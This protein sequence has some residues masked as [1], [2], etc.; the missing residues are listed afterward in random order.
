MRLKRNTIIADTFSLPEGSEVILN[1]WVNI[2]RNLGGILFLDLRDRSGIIQ[3][4]FD[5]EFLKTLRDEIGHIATEDVI[6]VKG[7]VQTRPLEAINKNMP[8]GHMEILVNDFELLN[9]AKTTPFEITKRE[10]GSEDLRLKYRYLDLRTTEM[11]KNMLLRSK[12]AASVRRFMDS[13]DFMDIETPM[14]MKS[15][16]EGARDYLVPSRVNPGKFYALPQSPQTYKQLLMIAGF[17]KYYQITKCFRDEDLRADRQPEFTQIDIEMSFVDENDVMTLA[18][19]LLASV[20]MD[21]VNKELS[22][23]LKRIPYHEAMEKYGS[24]K[25]DT[26]IETEIINIETIAKQMEFG[27]FQNS[28]ENGGVVRAL[29]LPGAAGLSRKNIDKLT[30]KAKS[31]GAKGLAFIKLTEQGIS[32]GISK[33]FTDEL[34]KELIHAVNAEQG[35]LVLFMADKWF[36]SLNVLGTLRVQLAQE[37]KQI[38]SSKFDALFVTRFP[39][40][41]WD[42]EHKRYIAMHHPFTSPMTEDIDKMDTEPAAVRARAYDLVLNGNEVAGGSIRI[43]QRDIQN[44]MFELLN[45]SEDERIAKFGFLLEA[46]QFGAPPHGGIAFGLDRL[47][48][49]LSANDSIR[50]VIAFPKTTT[51]QS[52]MDGAP[53]TV[54]KDQLNELK[55]LPGI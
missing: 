36:T 1:G 49:I 3:L 51:A 27:V 50:D 38:D 35:D 28:L 8:S 16:P 47:V 45:I 18:E 44:K 39:L 55:L 12:I 40:L 2:R 41:E 13:K 4:H 25:P 37:M 54:S 7:N 30:D 23:P 6:A 42:D 48:M 9:K 21:S 20:M 32:G 19:S 24:D 5:P 17:D 33:F 10:T 31:L 46:L 52:P 43:Y 34:A 14:L 29:R 11:Q 53:D 15:T 26:R 22:L